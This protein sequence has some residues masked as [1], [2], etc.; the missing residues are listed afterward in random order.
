MVTFII[1]S[2]PTVSDIITDFFMSP[3]ISRK[4][5]ILRLLVMKTSCLFHNSSLPRKLRYNRLPQVYKCRIRRTSVFLFSGSLPKYLSFF[6]TL[7]LRK[8]KNGKSPVFVNG[9]YKCPYHPPCGDHPNCIVGRKG[10]ACSQPDVQP[11]SGE[12]CLEIV[13]S[14]FFVM[15]RIIS[16]TKT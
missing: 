3:T 1:F 12:V 6:F 10:P 8:C 2:L 4:E 11:C 16:E 13:L 7:P 15:C 14:N 9:Y 5:T